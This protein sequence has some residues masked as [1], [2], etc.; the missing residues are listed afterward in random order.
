MMVGADATGESSPPRRRSAMRPAVEAL[1][2]RLLLDASSPATLPFP[3]STGSVVAEMGRS[4]QNTGDAPSTALP[5]YAMLLTFHDGDLASLQADG[6]SG[7]GWLDSRAVMA[8]FREGLWLGEQ[9]QL[10][11]PSDAPGHAPAPPFSGPIAA[12]A[13]GIATAS[14]GTTI[15]WEHASND[16]SS[17]TGQLLP[18]VSSTM[19]LGSLHGSDRSDVYQVQIAPSVSKLQIQFGRIGSQLPDSALIAVYDSDGKELGR[20]ALSADSPITELDLSDF[21]EAAG[22]R[23]NIGIIRPETHPDQGSGADSA[24]SCAGADRTGG[25]VA[26]G[27]G[28][29]EALLADYIMHVAVQHQGVLI[30][31]PAPNPPGVG[32]VPDGP[33]AGVFVGQAGS[34]VAAAQSASAPGVFFSTSQVSTDATVQAILLGTQPAMTGPLPSLAAAPMGG[35][36]GDGNPMPAIDA[37]ELV[38]VDLSLIT[39]GHDSTDDAEFDE[40]A[41]AALDANAELLDQDGGL[42]SIRGTGGFPLLASGLARGRGPG[43]NSLL[44]EQIADGPAAR[45]TSDSMAE[46]APPPTAEAN[47]LAEGARRRHGLVRRVSALIGLQAAATLS[48]GLLFPNL[49]EHLGAIR[50]RSLRRRRPKPLGS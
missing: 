19:V 44:V 21:L 37:R 43:S 35:A 17:K 48:F 26:P 42:S 7:Q 40:V 8:F 28:T 13:S 50:D 16:D 9:G 12:P 33:G 27:A 30:A 18:S 31:P 2:S 34:T 49:G 5:P 22:P 23:L 46:E 6:S 38:R 32:K 3:A 15:V 20:R 10:M 45:S 1:E 29:T 36:F 11:T 4:A 39:L 24:S 14:E 47:L 25:L 41:Q